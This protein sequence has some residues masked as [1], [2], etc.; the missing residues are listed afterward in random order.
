[1][2][3]QGVQKPQWN[4]IIY[5]PPRARIHISLYCLSLTVVQYV[6]IAYCKSTRKKTITMPGF[7]ATVA[8]NR[9]KTKEKIIVNFPLRLNA[10]FVCLFLS[11]VVNYECDDQKRRAENNAAFLN[12]TLIL[13]QCL[14]FFSTSFSSLCRFCLEIDFAWGLNCKNYKHSEYENYMHTHMG[15]VLNRPHTMI[16]HIYWCNADCCILLTKWISKKF[17]RALETREKQNVQQTK[18]FKVYLCSQLCV[19]SWYCMHLCTLLFVVFAEFLIYYQR[20]L[21]TLSVSIAHSDQN[22]AHERRKKKLWNWLHQTDTLHGSDTYSWRF[23]FSIGIRYCV[24][25]VFFLWHI[26]S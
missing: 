22:E 10:E 25:I 8:E 6:S 16:S 1:M 19:F 14:V 23:F 26:H 11:E 3:K 18:R 2:G 20:S 17:V 13:W 5:F 4:I 24:Y 12:A 9:N 15:Q 21:S 7:S